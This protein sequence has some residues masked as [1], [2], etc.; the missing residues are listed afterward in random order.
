MIPSSK[1]FRLG[2]FHHPS[3]EPCS[4]P[5]TEQ[6]VPWEW[7]STVQ[8]MKFF[9]VQNLT[10]FFP[11]LEAIWWR[12][13]GNNRRSHVLWLRKLDSIPAAVSHCLPCKTGQILGFCTAGPLGW[14]VFFLGA[15]CSSSV[16]RFKEMLSSYSCNRS[17]LGLWFEYNKCCNNARY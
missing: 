10:P 17:Q 9:S 4:L 3:P 1:Y 16:A 6:I 11:M 14:V 7:V 12:Q 2:S 13:W 8:S 5:C 15:Q